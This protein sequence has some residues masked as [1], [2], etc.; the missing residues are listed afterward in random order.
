[1]PK[2]ERIREELSCLPS[3]EYL[4]YK[5]AAGWKLAAIE[6]EREAETDAQAGALKLEVP[7]GLRVAKD[8]VH[9]EENPAE[10]EI[11]MLA[12]ELIVQDRS[13]SQ[14]AEELNRRGFWTRDG[15]KWGPVPVFDLLPRLV[16]VGPRI[17]SSEDWAE[18]RQHLYR[19]A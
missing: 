12:M 6:W 13:L 8:C 19:P 17:F 11:L 10:K 9:L 14:V 15:L 7:F 16:E 1:M 5:A 4:Q 18:R 3:A 2:I